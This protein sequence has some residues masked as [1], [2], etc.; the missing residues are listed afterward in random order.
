MNQVLQLRAFLRK[1]EEKAA[2]TPSHESSYTDGA[3]LAIG[4]FIALPVILVAT[5]KLRK[6]GTPI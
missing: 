5:L 1:A 4:I 6:M 2:S 3:I